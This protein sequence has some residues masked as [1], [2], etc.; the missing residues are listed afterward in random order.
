MRENSFVLCPFL[1][2]LNTNLILEFSIRINIVG[3]HV[4]MY[5][6]FAHKILLILSPAPSSGDHQNDIHGITV[7][8]ENTP[9]ILSRLRQTLETFSG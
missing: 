9:K 7:R 2:E 1:A 3:K 4:P 6:S 8:M 5:V